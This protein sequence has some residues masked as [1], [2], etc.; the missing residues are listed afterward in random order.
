MTFNI[1][2]LPKTLPGGC[3]QWTLILDGRVVARSR[4]AYN[5]REEATREVKQ[6]IFLAPGAG[7]RYDHSTYDSL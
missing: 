7:I 5:T 3:W 2:K 1:T 4:V 6:I